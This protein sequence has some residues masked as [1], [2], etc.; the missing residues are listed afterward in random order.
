VATYCNSKPGKLIHWRNRQL[1]N[2]PG[3]Q[4]VRE[5][6]EALLYR[7]LS[8]GV[9]VKSPSHEE[10]QLGC[11]SMEPEGFPVALR[12]RGLCPYFSS[13]TYSN[14][15]EGFANSNEPE[16]AVARSGSRSH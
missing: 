11:F 8:F 13:M 5:A 7:S 14:E 3:G 9:V 2:W 16:L 1:A 12:S 6:P 15:P 10:K 4:L